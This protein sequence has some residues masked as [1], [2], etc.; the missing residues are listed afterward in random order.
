M[1]SRPRPPGRRAPWETPC[2]RSGSGALLVCSLGCPRRASSV[3]AGA[4]SGWP[5]RIAPRARLGT[6]ARPQPWVEAPPGGGVAAGVGRAP[7]PPRRRA[8][9]RG[10][11][12]GPATGRS[13]EVHRQA[14]VRAEAILA[15]VDRGAAW[16]GGDPGLAQH[17]HGLRSASGASSARAA[18][19]RFAASVS[20]LASTSCRCAGRSGAGCRPDPRGRGRR[21]RA[22]CASAIAGD[23]PAHP[24]PAPRAGSPGNLRSL[25]GAVRTRRSALVPTTPM[26]VALPTRAL[27][28]RH[29][30][31]LH[32]RAAWWL[33]RPSTLPCY[34]VRPR[35]P[36]ELSPCG[37]Q[38]R[39]H[40][41][42]RRTARR[43]CVLRSRGSALPDGLRAALPGGELE[44]RARAF[45]SS[46]IQAPAGGCP[47]GVRRA[48]AR[49]TPAPP[50]PPARSPPARGHQHRVRR[51]DPQ[52]HGRPDPPPE[53]PQLHP[54]AP[55]AESASARGRSASPRAPG[56]AGNST[57]GR[58]GSSPSCG[59]RLGAR[60]RTEAIEVDAAWQHLRPAAR[61]AAAAP[62]ERAPT[63]RHQ[64]HRGSAARGDQRVRG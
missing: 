58:S 6:R 29:R 49:R 19:C 30:Y 51:V 10:R 37:R 41:R 25:D 5:A 24:K 56:S 48:P 23:A 32:R 38:P 55:R 44:R 16:A 17:R 14:A 60:Q 28:V 45:P 12:G 15:A 53:R 2:R 21:A 33:G 54:C 57:S 31:G 9:V 18:R 27:P 63:R 1:G 61:R 8:P 13:A 42:A 39:R 64:V 59:S 46:P 52:R 11:G 4:L 34:P 36:P 3:G 43:G 62:V 22:P 26:Q 35:R 7:A 40:R 47:P 20:S 50:A